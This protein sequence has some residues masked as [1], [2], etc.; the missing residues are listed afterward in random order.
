MIIHNA[1]LRGRDG[2]Y[3]ITLNGAEIAAIDIQTASATPAAGDLDR[4]VST[5]V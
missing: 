1:R 5:S 4:V 2:L 3:R